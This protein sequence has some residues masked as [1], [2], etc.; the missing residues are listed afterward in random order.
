[1]P[2]AATVRRWATGGPVLRR[3][4]LVALTATFFVIG[5]TV[6]ALAVTAGT[7]PLTAFIAAAVMYSATSELAYLA[8]VAG[9]GSTATGVLSGWLVASRFG[10]LAITLA[11]IY[12]RH[13][14]LWKRVLAAYVVVDPSI[15]MAAN[16]GDLEAQ[17]RTYVAL[18]VWMSLGWVAGSL[19]GILLGDRI[20]DPGAIGLDAVFP[21]SLVAI[22]APQLRRRDSQVAAVVAVAVTLGLV[23]VTPGGLPVLLSVAGAAVAVLLVRDPA[24]GVPAPGPAVGSGSEPS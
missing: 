17:Q 24:A 19:V 8:V 13:L 1:M 12:G 14:P 22:L 21:A 6:S 9:G 7:T 15:A 23:E 16:E 18:S 4:D 2:L 5:I 10:L 11:R 3:G 20:G